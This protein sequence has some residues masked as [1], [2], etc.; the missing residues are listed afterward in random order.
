MQLE[1]HPV[2]MYYNRGLCV[3]HIFAASGGTPKGIAFKELIC[4]LVLLTRGKQEEKIKCK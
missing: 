2:E 1:V 4:G 3:Q